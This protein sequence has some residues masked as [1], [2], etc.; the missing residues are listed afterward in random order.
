MPDAIGFLDK[1]REIL[2][3][4]KFSDKLNAEEDAGEKMALFQFLQEAKDILRQLY[5]NKM[6]IVPQNLF[7]CK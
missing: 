2:I 1:T 5:S 4:T 3:G 6:Y 7:S